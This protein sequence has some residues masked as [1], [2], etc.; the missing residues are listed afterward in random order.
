MLGTS[1]PGGP[2][3][4]LAP[5]SLRCPRSVSVLCLLGLWWELP[6]ARICFQAEHLLAEPGGPLL[7]HFPF[8]GQAPWSE[9]VPRSTGVTRTC[10]E[11][12]RG[13]SSDLGLLSQ[14]PL[15][16]VQIKLEKP[17]LCLHRARRAGTPWA[18]ATPLP[19]PSLAWLLSTLSPS[20]PE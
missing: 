18:A 12:R 13:H 10:G 1:D 6:S 7:A 9:C 5:T 11:G 3:Q 15:G 20:Q 8:C 14:Q 19:S 4:G 17:G 2:P 16:H